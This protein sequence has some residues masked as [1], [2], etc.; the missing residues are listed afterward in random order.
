MERLQN[1]KLYILVSYLR[2]ENDYNLSTK[3]SGTRSE[4]G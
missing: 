4:V 3:K 2:I 1:R